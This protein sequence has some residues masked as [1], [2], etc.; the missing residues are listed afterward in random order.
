[1][2]H[3]N[4]PHSV[5]TDS[6]LP[7]PDPSIAVADPTPT[8]QNTPVPT[9]A[10][11]IN[12]NEPPSTT[13]SGTT[14]GSWARR[15]NK[16]VLDLVSSHSATR[17]LGTNDG[18]N[19]GNG[20]GGI[21]DDTRAVVRPLQLSSSLSMGALDGRDDAQNKRVKQTC[22]CFA[23]LFAVSHYPSPATASYDSCTHD[24]D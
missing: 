6:P 13:T 1:M 14:W 15:N 17:S 21:D 5:D 20:T 4:I 3:A 18:G 23:L 10:S 24:D 12:D 7:S 16:R 11:D 22:C 2:M 8:S 9:E 19:G